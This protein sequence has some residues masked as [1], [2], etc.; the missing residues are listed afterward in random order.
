[1]KDPGLKKVIEAV[2]T[3]EELAQKLRVT[4]Q[5]VSQWQKVPP[6]RVLEVEKISGIPRHIIRPDLYPA[7]QS[8]TAA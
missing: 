8:H 4:K 5:A 7:D 6:I 2:G 1:M 3:Q